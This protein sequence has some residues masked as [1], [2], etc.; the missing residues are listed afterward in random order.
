M[1]EKIIVL[2]LCFAVFVYIYFLIRKIVKVEEIK[3]INKEEHNWKFSSNRKGDTG[4]L[5]FG[6]KG[7][8]DIDEYHCTK[9]WKT[10]EI[11]NI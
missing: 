4:D 9:C 10:K 2:F 1:L 3:C 8:W 6:I 7:F 11:E 5:G